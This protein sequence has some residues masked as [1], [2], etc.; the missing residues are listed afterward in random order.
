MRLARESMKLTKLHK[1]FLALIMMTLCSA[2][3]LRGVG[4]AGREEASRDAVIGVET[5]REAIRIRWG[6]TGGCRAS[7]IEIT[8][9]GIT[10]LV[11]REVIYAG[12]RDRLQEGCP[13]GM[14]IPPERADDDGDGLLNEDFLDGKDN[15][16]DGL[17]DEDFAAVGDRMTVVE[18]ASRHTGFR[19]LNRIFSWTY[20]HVSDFAG[21]ST[22][23]DAGPA[24]DLPDTLALRLEYLSPAEGCG[25]DDRIFARV[26]A[27]TGISGEDTLRVP[28][29]SDGNSIAGVIILEGRAGY[30]LEAERMPGAGRPEGA[31]TGDWQLCSSASIVI[32]LNQPEKEAGAG[33]EEICWAVVFGETDKQVE[34]S[35][36]AA[37]S[38]YL[39]AET[40]GGG[41]MRWVVPARM[42]QV[43]ELESRHVV[44]WN[45]GRGGRAL[46]I[47]VPLELTGLG[48]KWLK[49]NGRQLT[50]YTV[51]G[52]GILIDRPAESEGP[53]E[54]EGEFSE[55]TLF[56]S[57]AYPEEPGRQESDSS[58][59]LP[60]SFVK[61]YPNPFVDN[62]N[63]TLEIT[64]SMDL[65]S[66]RNSGVIGG[67]S[68]VKIYDV[69][70]E[71]VK[72]ISEREFMPP[73]G[74]NLQWDGTD[75]R[76]QKVAPGVYYVTLKIGD[77]SRTKRVILLK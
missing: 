5:G 35:A 70:G 9:V 74:Y 38:T 43:V 50:S 25:S 13:G 59:M 60:E 73:G 31:G 17:V 62:V 36:R 55:G 6:D 45:D 57:V 58:I 41:N 16:G 44:S 18:T 76:Q 61:L 7:G 19:L 47:E 54:I 51:T 4:G 30:R 1:M 11:C 52:R 37:L 3:L 42:V 22:V 8:V 56:R 10:G 69:R 77:R 46:E 53:V 64:R 49:A 26:M 24:E 75:R 20:N 34:S 39:G 33:E 12:G 65:F 68:S 67:S 63:I 15:D 2:G 40:E 32:N 21:I 27:L 72:T 14:R 28:L 23:L 48:I 29:L 66:G 71:L